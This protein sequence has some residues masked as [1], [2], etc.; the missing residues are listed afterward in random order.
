VSKL[1]AWVGIIAFATGVAWSFSTEITPA[2]LMAFGA[3][4]YAFSFD[5]RE[6]EG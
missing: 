1:F 4:S 6:D 3:F 5:W 2:Q